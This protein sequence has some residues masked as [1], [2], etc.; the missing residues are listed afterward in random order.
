VAA[1]RVTPA[2]VDE[3]ISAFPAE[4]RSILQEVRAT[5]RSAAPEA[6]EKISYGMPTFALD[7]EIVHFA[8]F[9]R[10]IGLFPPVRDPELLEATIQYRGEKGNLRFP[11][12][13]P[14]PLA[15]IGRIVEARL[16]EISQQPKQGRGTARSEPR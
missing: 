1:A 2:T 6:V 16:R 14:M 8:A 7:R 13:Q 9:K 15:L 11:L 10:H 5:I 3:Y 4:I 12:D